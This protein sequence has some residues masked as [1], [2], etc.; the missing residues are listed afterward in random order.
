MWTGPRGGGASGGRG[1]SGASS[2][3]GGGPLWSDAGNGTGGTGG[4]AGTK[5][6][7]LD[8]HQLEYLPPQIVI[9]LD[10]SGSMLEPAPSGGSRWQV[11]TSAVDDVV[12]K[13]AT[14]TDWGLK[15]FPTPKLDGC[16]VNVGADVPVARDS[17]ARI[18]ALIKSTV[19]AV[20]DGLPATPTGPG[21]RAAAAYLKQVA[22]KNAKY[23]VL[24]TDGQPSCPGT[25]TEAAADAVLALQ[26]TAMANI[27]TYVIGINI[28]PKWI[29]VLNNMADAGGTARA[30]TVK[31]YPAEAHQ[32]LV[33]TLADIPRKVSSCVFTLSKAPPSPDDVAVDVGMPPTR[34]GRDAARKNGWEYTDGTRT[35]IE[36]YGSV[37]ESIKTGAVSN[38]QITFGC[39]FVPIP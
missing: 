14:L 7:G 35:A 34:L 1:G 3:I 5:T 29:A 8:K 37:C 26:Q 2:G 6:C 17:S 30:G 25:G 27:K 32:D 12:V 20:A 21:I 9:V 36:I 28:N 31:Y 22:S 19:A 16:N 10:R 18:S 4:D 33:A 38:V 13:T 15:F 11:V 23:L 39:P 24:A